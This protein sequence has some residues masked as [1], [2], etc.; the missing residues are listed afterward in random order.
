MTQ[1]IAFA[2]LAFAI[3]IAIFAVQNT[4]PVAV[5]FLML[6]AQGVAVSVLVLIS[7][8]LGAGFMLLLGLS[9]EIRAGFRHRALSNQLRAAEARV[10]DLEGRAT[11]VTEVPPQALSGGEPTTQL[12]TPLDLS[13]SGPSGS[14]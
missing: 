12:T 7:A 1:V 2:A 6:Q 13:S 3:V 8:A 11:P 9:R 10:K 4:T 14:S 5:S